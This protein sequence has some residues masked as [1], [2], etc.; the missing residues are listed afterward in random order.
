[1][2]DPLR[3]RAPPPG[4]VPRWD[5]SLA[6][7]VAERERLEGGPQRDET[8]PVGTAGWTRRV[9]FVRERLESGP[10]PPRARPKRSAG[11]AGEGAGAGA[12]KRPAARGRVGAE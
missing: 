1:M 12:R 7:L 5:E 9:H 8:S 3:M 2:T 10:Q 11:R 6:S 4:P